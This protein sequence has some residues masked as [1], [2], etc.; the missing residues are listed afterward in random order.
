MELVAI[1]KAHTHVPVLQ[2][3]QELTVKKVL[4]YIFLI[5]ETSYLLNVLLVKTMY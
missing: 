3:G 4:K 1:T 5:L 2:G